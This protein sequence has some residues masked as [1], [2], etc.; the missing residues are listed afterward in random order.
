MRKIILRTHLSPGD[1]CTLT[2]AIDSLHTMYP[3]QYLT[4]VRT[5]CDELFLHNPHITRLQDGEADAIE[6]HYTDLISCCDGVPNPF[7]RGYCDHLGKA[8]GLPL[9]LKTNRPHL[10]LSEEEK[11]ADP[12]EGQGGGGSTKYWLVTAGI[13]RDFTVKQW[14]VEY[15][16]EVVNHFRGKVRFVQIGSTEHDHPA[17]DGVVDRVGKTDVRQL[18]RLAYHAQRL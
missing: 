16:Q 11:R 5:A 8:L 9:E 4:D 18:I 13:K 6:M 12:L 17:L 1:I 3:G 15:Y 2:A 7:L 14:P 10:Y